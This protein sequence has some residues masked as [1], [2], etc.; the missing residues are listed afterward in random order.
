M[1]DLKTQCVG[2]ILE[3]MGLGIP[4]RYCWTLRVA[5]VRD[6]DPWQGFNVINYNF[7]PVTYKPSPYVNGTL[8]SYS[9]FSYFIGTTRHY[10]ALD[11]RVD[12]SQP[13]VTAAALGNNVV[14]VDDAVFFQTATS[15]AFL[16]RISRDDA[17]SIRYL[18]SPQNRN[19]ELA[20]T[21]TAIQGTSF[22]TSVGA[23]GSGGG[24]SPWTPVIITAPVAGGG[25]DP[26]AGGGA[27]NA[28]PVL[29]TAG[30]RAGVDKIS[31]ARVDLDPIL[32]RIN[33]PL[34]VR[35]SETV[36]TTNGVVNQ[37]VER[38]LTV[39]DIIISAANLNQGGLALSMTFINNAAI[40]GISG[41]ANGGP[42]NLE[43]TQEITFNNAGRIIQN[44]VIGERQVDGFLDFICGS[45]DC[46]T[47]APVTYPQGRYTFAELQALAQQGQVQ[48]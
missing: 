6:T 11:F 18:Y 30:V 19:Y 29:V 35:Y 15:G 21:G 16:E 44:G 40:D 8:Y 17:G 28:G 46:S 42:G 7:D 33:T 10:D 31:F 14:L 20:P 47:N 26:N 9:I 41:L 48:P 2:A 13:N 1:I 38:L 22:G 4:E 5:I 39:P 43:G 12:P 45:F 27:T 32:R 25:T 3:Q 36:T 23:G 34:L 24:G 37:R